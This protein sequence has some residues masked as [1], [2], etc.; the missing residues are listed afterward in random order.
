MITAAVAA[1]A[2]LVSPV[3]AIDA[4]GA[5]APRALGWGTCTDTARPYEC[6]TLRVPL[7][8]SDPGRAALDLPLIRRPASDPAHRIGTL[9]LQPGGPGGSGVDFLRDNYAD[10]PEELRQRFDV[11]GFDAR[12]VGRATQVRCW[13]DARYSRAVAEAAGMPGP[14][15]AARAITE[16]EDFDAACVENSG[17]Y[18]PYLGTGFVAR[19]ID[20]IR[21][22]LGEQQLSFYGRSFGTLIGTVYAD[23]FPG[24][25]RAMALDG[26]YDPVAYADRPYAFDLAQFVAL[27]GAVDRLLD[28]CGRTP[29]QCAFGNGDPH[30]AFDRLVRQL[31]A[32]PVA[33]P[34]GGTANGYTVVYR[35]IF[36]INGGRADWPDLAAALARAEARDTSSFLLSP[37]SSGSFA[38]LTPNVVVE[39]NDR[40]Y[41]PGDDLLA[42]RLRQ[43]AEQ[44]PL[45]GPAMAYGPPTYDHNHA[46]ACTRWPAERASRHAGPFRAQGSAPLLVLG[47]T[48]DPDTPYQDAV[49]LADTLDNAQLLTFAAE[50]HTAFGRSR[51]A[52]DAVVAY[53]VAGTM[54]PQGLVCTDEKEPRTRS[55]GARAEEPAAPGTVGA[56]DHREI[57]G[58]PDR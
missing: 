22:A 33:L 53:F 57:I 25:V 52:R 29:A 12:G 47:T 55:D 9:V 10:L 38:F 37:P 13:D 5:A 44:A 39:C 2:L 30:G 46:P 58:T 49:T 3:A 1:L 28:W 35:L 7:D 11:V 45:L 15:W 21:D 48:G 20:R 42:T 43:A 34:G 32:D 14:D 54:P 26:A 19:D 51:C 56:D 31:D 27:D 24:R 8:Y 36:N 40:V 6:S 16:A 4:P 18:L 50:G 41:P 17:A 23:M